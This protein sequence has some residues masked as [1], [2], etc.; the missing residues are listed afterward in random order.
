MV[1]GQNVSRLSQ[2]I[3]S[4]YGALLPGGP[5]SLNL[6][7]LAGHAG[8]FNPL[9]APIRHTGILADLATPGSYRARLAP[10]VVMGVGNMRVRFQAVA[11]VAVD[12]AQVDVTFH[13]SPWGEIDIRHID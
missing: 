8:V 4:Q 11:G 13:V 7:F 2:C 3:I 12:L 9:I 1:A 10:G 6:D 5:G